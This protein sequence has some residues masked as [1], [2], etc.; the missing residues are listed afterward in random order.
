M[1]VQ[2]CEATVVSIYHNQTVQFR[3]PNNWVK[4]EEF[5][6]LLVNEQNKSWI[7]GVDKGTKYRLIAKYE[8]HNGIFVR[9]GMIFFCVI[10][11]L[12]VVSLLFQSGRELVL[13]LFFNAARETHFLREIE[14]VPNGESVEVYASITGN[15]SHMGHMHMIALAVNRLVNEGYVVDQVKVALSSEEYL[16]LKVDMCNL[17]I[18]HKNE[19]GEMLKVLLPREKR[20]DFLRAAIQQAKD[21]RTF[22]Q[23]LNIDYFEEHKTPRQSTRKVFQACG[24]D[25]LI[26]PDKLKDHAVIVTRADKVEI[27]EIHTAA[28]SRL[29]VRNDDETKAYSSSMIQNGAYEQLPD[30]VRDEFKIMHQTK[31]VRSN[32]GINSRK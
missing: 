16:Q 24:A 29:I 19:V 2:N 1:K 30:S 10:L 7:E 9:I 26:E 6:N 14:Y 8:Q 5:Q 31:N 21:N 23:S 12:T 3:I 27:M 22:S 17:T 25:F 32:L 11:S 13:R 28:Y 15:P 4:I 18:K 20:I